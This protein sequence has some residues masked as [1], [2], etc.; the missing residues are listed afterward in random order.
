MFWAREDKDR[1]L[2]SL[3]TGLQVQ[4][5]S[6]CG[7][8][9]LPWWLSRCTP[10][11]WLPWCSWL[12]F[13]RA[14]RAACTTRCWSGWTAA[15]ASWCPWWP[16]RPASRTVSPL[17]CS[18]PEL[19]CCLGCVPGGISHVWAQS[20]MMVQSWCCP[21]LLLYLVKCCCSLSAWLLKLQRCETFW[22]CHQEHSVENTHLLIAAT[23]LW[24]LP[25]SGCGSSQT[26]YCFT[27]Y[28]WLLGIYC[29]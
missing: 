13:T 10:S 26:H 8:A 9:C 18:P 21:W 1:M 5:T 28:F 6:R 24:S 27:I 25:R 3:S 22:V 4:T 11:P 23:V 17:A 29:L 7:M 15:C 19:W 2:V 12:C 14:R 20:L 16:F